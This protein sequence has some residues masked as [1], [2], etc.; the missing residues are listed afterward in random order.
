MIVHICQNSQSCTLK[1]V[2]LNM[3]ESPGGS[4]LIIKLRSSG[5]YMMILKK[6]GEISLAKEERQFPWRSEE[7]PFS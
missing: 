2:Y 4:L 5:G 6:M 7:Q 3:F 1:V